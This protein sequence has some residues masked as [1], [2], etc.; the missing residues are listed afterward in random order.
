MTAYNEDE[1]Q[2]KPTA[3]EVKD[4]D[5]LEEKDLRRTTFMFGSEEK[6]GTEPDM[7]SNGAGGHRFGENANTPSGDDGNNPS[8]NAGYSNEYFRRSEPSEEHPENNNFRDPNQLG[9]S[10][11]TEATGAAP[12]GQSDEENTGPEKEGGE[13]SS[14]E[15][16]DEQNETYQEGTADNDGATSGTNADG[17]V[18]G[19]GELP[20][21]QKVGE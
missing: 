16:K 12:T 19:Y 17:D 1:E 9:Q 15:N 5:N 6:D 2:N 11:Y 3:Y 21:Q 13:D 7:E 8:Q 4:D 14:E 20:E 10:N 18:A